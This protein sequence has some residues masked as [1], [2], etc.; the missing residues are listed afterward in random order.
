MPV[1][2]NP[3]RVSLISASLG[4]ALIAVLATYLRRKRRRR[5]TY[6]GSKGHS[7]EVS[8]KGDGPRQTSFFRSKRGR[9]PTIANGGKLIGI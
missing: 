2:N 8:E 6:R 5:P 1:I 7:S 4:I 9:S 3:V